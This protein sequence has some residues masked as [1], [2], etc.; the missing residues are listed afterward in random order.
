MVT[1]EKPP[2]GFFFSFSDFSVII[3]KYKINLINVNED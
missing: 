2:R 1:I 3:I